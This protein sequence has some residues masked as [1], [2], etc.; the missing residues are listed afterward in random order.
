MSPPI[1][2]P[3]LAIHSEI[4]GWNCIT[5]NL[6]QDPLAKT[7]L[8]SNMLDRKRVMV[9]QGAHHELMARDGDLPVPRPSANEWGARKTALHQGSIGHADS[10]FNT[11]HPAM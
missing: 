10:S 5:Q 11:G 7:W 2:E 9:G 4:D 3:R 6:R 8:V 1:S